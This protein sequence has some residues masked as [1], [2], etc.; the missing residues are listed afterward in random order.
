VRHN[1][2][3]GS[4][5]VIKACRTAGVRF[6]IISTGIKPALEVDAQSRYQD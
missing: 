1:G 5:K 4:G 6:R 2:H 3:N